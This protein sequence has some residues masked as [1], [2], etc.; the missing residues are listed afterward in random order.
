MRVV[1]KSFTPAVLL[2]AGV[3]A[4]AVVAATPAAADGR[5]S[6]PNPQNCAPSATSTMCL[7]QGDAEINSSIPAP[8]SGPMGIYGPYWVKG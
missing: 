8:Y 1:L 4:A 6:P 2:L 3:A 7:R 5:Q